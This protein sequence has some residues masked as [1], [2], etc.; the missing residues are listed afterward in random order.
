MRLHV[1]HE[2]SWVVAACGAHA[3]ARRYYHAAVV[4][5]NPLAA[6]SRND[7]TTTAVATPKAKVNDST[8]HR[9]RAATTDH[10]NENAAARALKTF[11]ARRRN[12]RARARSAGGRMIGRIVVVVLKSCCG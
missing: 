9:P 1:F 12:E 10:R 8:A 3:R 11:T 6:E 5:S 7:L 4:K 2:K